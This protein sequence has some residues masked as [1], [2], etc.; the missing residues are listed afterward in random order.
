MGNKWP[1]G[2][3]FKGL[4]AVKTLP[5]GSDPQNHHPTC[6]RSDSYILHEV[7]REGG[8]A[9][10]KVLCG[11]SCDPRGCEFGS[12]YIRRDLAH[13]PPIKRKGAHYAKGDAEWM[14]VHEI[15]DDLGISRRDAHRIAT[16]LEH[17]KPSEKKA[18]LVRRRAYAEW[19]AE[20]AGKG[21]LPVSKRF[22]SAPGSDAGQGL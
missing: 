21:D 22:E 3:D 11:V 7:C 15:M 19:K 13:R 14:P 5:E 1:Y 18:L 16:K 9:D 8:Y 6:T 4:H 2:D 10:G 12:E 20:H 17:Y